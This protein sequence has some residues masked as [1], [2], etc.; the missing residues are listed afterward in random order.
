M[1]IWRSSN[2]PDPSKASSVEE[3]LEK[4]VA[5]D[6]K[7]INAKLLLVAFYIKSILTAAGRRPNR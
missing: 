3:E 6:P 7:L 1:T 5:L 2:R 4:S